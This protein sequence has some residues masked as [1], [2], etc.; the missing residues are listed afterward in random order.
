[1]RTLIPFLCL[2]LAA[3]LIDSR[4]YSNQAAPIDAPVSDGLVEGPQAIL[5]DEMS[6]LALTVA[7]GG[8]SR[9]AV[10]LRNPPVVSLEVAIAAADNALA[11]ATP[12]IL[13]FDASNWNVPQ[14]IEISGSQDDDNDPETT[15]VAL[16][17]P[18]TLAAAVNVT[19]NDDESQAVLVSL[20]D[21]NLLEGG[22]VQVGV[23]LR[24]A[25]A[26]NVAVAVSSDHETVAT[27]SPATLTFTPTSY[28]QPQN[29]TIVAAQ[30]ANTVQDVT[31]ITMTL[32][33]ATTGTVGI[34]VPDDDVLGFVVSAG[35]LTVNENGT[36][37]STFTVAL[38]NMP[39]GTVSAA[40]TPAIAGSYT[41]SPSTITFNGANWN[42]PVTVT[43]T[44]VR[45]SDNVDEASQLRVTATDVVTGAVDV[46]VNDTTEIL[47]L[48]WPTF[49]NRTVLDSGGFVH[50]FKFTV[51]GAP[52]TIDKWGMITGHTGPNM[53]RMG[54]YTN[55][56][57]S[58]GSLIASSGAFPIRV[59]EYDVP[60]TVTLSAGTYWMVRQMGAETAIGESSSSTAPGMYCNDMIPFATPLP[61]TWDSTGDLC[62][63]LPNTNIYIIGYR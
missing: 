48:G 1:M 16:S 12:A 5:V 4:T 2:S 8:S 13:T 44:A 18:Q 9:V 25:P 3:C 51:S 15:S 63:T 62:V 17:A 30:D 52:V 36:G 24:F 57:D 20:A 28:A 40:L 53:A 45:D 22:S 33:D 41:V 27:V 21:V 35:S 6:E 23:R 61:A 32:A 37:A 29:V 50:A 26:A 19:V 43:V 38:S 56:A 60:D 11:T 10:T 55:G 34:T 58:P 47:S 42:V 46:T 54:V 59:G 14:L 39:G 31:T 49:F 7:E